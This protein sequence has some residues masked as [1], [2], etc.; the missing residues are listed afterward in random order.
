MY[1]AGSSHRAAGAVPSDL[2]PQVRTGQAENVSTFNKE[3]MY[4]QKGTEAANGER[5]KG[6][7]E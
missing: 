7:G 5:K 4:V 3:E 6:T 2:Y 1:A